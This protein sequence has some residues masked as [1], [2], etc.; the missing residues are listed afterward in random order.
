MRSTDSPIVR[1]MLGTFT[2]DTYMNTLNSAEDNVWHKKV[3][4]G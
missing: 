2:V 4:W 1:V 3:Q